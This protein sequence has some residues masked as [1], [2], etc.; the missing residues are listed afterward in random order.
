MLQNSVT[1]QKT[2]MLPST[3]EQLLL[4]FVRPKLFFSKR[5]YWSKSKVEPAANAVTIVA[6][7]IYLA[8]AAVS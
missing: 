1:L 7:E 5:V 8:S 3:K 4:A 2:V 6:F